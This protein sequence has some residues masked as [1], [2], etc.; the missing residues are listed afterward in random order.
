MQSMLE[1]LCRQHQ[2]LIGCCS[3]NEKQMVLMEQSKSPALIQNSSRKN[4]D[5]KNHTKREFLY[6]KHLY[7]VLLNVC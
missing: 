2:Q 5:K 1:A 4:P 3:S 7:H 6:N